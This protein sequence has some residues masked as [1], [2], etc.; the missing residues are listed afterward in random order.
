M[1]VLGTAYALCWIGHRPGAGKS[2]VL[3]AQSGR[4]LCEATYGANYYLETARHIASTVT[5]IPLHGTPTCKF[6]RGILQRS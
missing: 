4:G 2:H 1:T 5:P 6:C 3:D